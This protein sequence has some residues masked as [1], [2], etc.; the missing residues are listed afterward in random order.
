MLIFYEDSDTEITKAKKLSVHDQ[1]TYLPKFTG[2]RIGNY[3]AL[4][5]QCKKKRPLSTHF[6]A[7]HI[8]I[9][10]LILTYFPG[11]DRDESECKVQG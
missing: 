10:H 11:V 8:L 9:L 3:S 2:K 4:S 6:L 7:E 1:K 5:V